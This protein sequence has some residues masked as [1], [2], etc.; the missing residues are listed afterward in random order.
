MSDGF[1]ANYQ[2]DIRPKEPVRPGWFTSW[3]GGKRMA[4]EI[5]VLH[6]WE[7]TPWHRSRPFPPTAYHKFDYLALGS[8]EYGARHGI[9]RLLDVFDAHNVKTT[10]TTNGLVAQ[11]FPKS[12]RAAAD[13][14][15]ELS[16]HQWDQAVFPPMFTS[17]DAEKKSMKQAKDL[18]EQVSGTR[19]DGYMSPGPRP[20]PNTMSILPELGFK[21]TCDY[22]D[23]DFP[24]LIKTEPYPI[25]AVSYA[26]PGCIDYDLLPHSH[27]NRLEELK[28]VFD[29]VHAESAKQPMR[30]SY[31]VHAHWGG[32]VPMARVLDEFLRHVLQHDDVWVSTFGQVADLWLANSQD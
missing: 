19:V 28:F 12:V 2:W 26:T 23:C 27:P 29:A 14:G 5:I 9:W 13:R 7:S 24:Y 25:V 18:I 4:F 22:V 21:W 3:P 1:I 16:V 15:H 17:R 11:L 20:T 32:T 30:F 6:E 8:R 31:A 10:I